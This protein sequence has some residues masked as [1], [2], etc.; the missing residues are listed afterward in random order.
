MG[1]FDTTV[2]SYGNVPLTSPIGTRRSDSALPITRKDKQKLARWLY[3]RNGVIR[4]AIRKMADYPIT[5]VLIKVDLESYRQDSDRDR[6]KEFLEDFYYRRLKIN[7]VLKEIGINFQ[8]YGISLTYLWFGTQTWLECPH[9]HR[10]HMLDNLEEDSW[11]LVNKGK[12]EIGFTGD[13]PSC[14]KKGVAFIET[15]EILKK[16]DKLK[17]VTFDPVQ[18]EI[19]EH[20]IT[21]ECI[22]WYRPSQRTRERIMSGDKWTIKNSSVDLLKAVYS[23]S[24]LKLNPDNLFIMKNV[25]PSQV[26][27]PWPEPTAL[28]AF[29]QIY[30]NLLLDKASEAIAVQHIVPLPIFYP[31]L[32]GSEGIDKGSLAIQSFKT[33]LAA[34][35]KQWV[36]NPNHFVISGIPIGVEQA[37]GRGNMQFPTNQQSYNMEEALLAM[38]VPR[39]LLTGSV[40]YAGG[41]AAMRIVENSW[42]VSHNGLQDACDFISRNV[43]SY[44]PG[45][46]KH[47]LE[48]K[49]FRRMDDVMYKNQVTQGLQFGIVSPQ[50]WCNMFDLDYS[51]Q[52][53]QIK[54]HRVWEANLNAEIYLI[55][56][57]AQ[58][59]ADM[60][61]Q[62]A[63]A[64]I[65]AE[66][67]DSMRK[68][69]QD[70]IANLYI[71]YTNA[72]LAP[73]QAI[74]VIMAHLQSVNNFYA[75]QGV[76]AE[77][78]MARNAFLTREMANA[79]VSYNRGQRDKALFN[80]MSM[81]QP[82]QPPAAGEDRITFL[83][84]MMMAAPEEQR[85][86]MLTQLEAYDKE[87]YDAVVQ[88]LKMN[89]INAAA[90][91]E[92]SSSSGI[93][94]AS[95]T[96]PLPDMMPPRQ[97]GMG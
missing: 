25:D 86:S 92:G 41:T 58:A 91:P 76:M 62:G 44:I 21:K 23:D 24:M 2:N 80:T 73:Q 63:M 52:T 46:V 84:N 82:F 17:V 31:R 87:T 1:S 53:K 95:R 64:A 10:N 72:G 16:P 59:Q 42:I 35:I 14:S 33:D 69:Q 4:H 47:E 55:N 75:M 5:K 19:K 7:Q 40:H 60:E 96:A 94:E 38:G 90:S 93:G 81:D 49:D 3:K 79:Q 50:E 56:S 20:E 11:K 9:C 48:L 85:T 36:R 77:A 39:G 51:D 29:S 6:V 15:E 65:S 97:Q 88:N 12:G 57:R 8:T 54:E 61:L 43:Q 37:L 22:Y 27:Q 68:T 83:T 13:C 30:N 70:D 45:M 34:E 74:Q 32:D 71:R 26:N 67:A 89:G 28:G 66:Q 18:V 78:S